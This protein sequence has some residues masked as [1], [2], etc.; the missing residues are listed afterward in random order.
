MHIVKRGLL[1]LSALALIGSTAGLY[2]A[3]T[4]SAG[5][6][7]GAETITATQYGVGN[8][9]A[10]GPWNG[11]G[12][13]NTGGVITDDNN[14]TAGNLHTL[15]APNGS[16]TVYTSEGVQGP[17][18][19]NPY[20]CAFSATNTD[21]DV[22]IVSGTGIYKHATGHFV[23]TAIIKGF[24]QQTPTGC[25]TNMN[26]PEAFDSVAVVAKGYIDLH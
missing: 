14:A 6:T 15:V 8:A 17:F 18:N 24:I 21:V 11:R 20:T 10:V 19:L 5:V 23:A 3:A 2:A 1:G 26:D 16:F 13:I 12:A 22:H 25:D 4:A 9:N 7:K